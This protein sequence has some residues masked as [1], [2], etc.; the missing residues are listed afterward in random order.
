MTLILTAICKDGICICADRRYKYDNGLTEDK[1]KKTYKFQ[2]ITYVIA[3]HGLNEIDGKDWKTYCSEYEA[4]GG[5]KNKSHFSIV[6]DFKDYMEDY[7]R[8]ELS[9]HKDR[10]K[11]AMGFL[12]GGKQSTEN[13]YK[14][15][16]IHWLRNNN[17]TEFKLSPI[18]TNKKEP[19]IVSGSDWIKDYLKEYTEANPDQYKI[20]PKLKQAEKILNDLFEIAVTEKQKRK[21]GDFSDERD[22]EFVRDSL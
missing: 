22:I 6:N 17:E 11:N 9:R 21:S 8:K 18:H 1:H 3:H 16:E 15:S 5:W 20:I 2:G 12:L 7:V 13:K 10:E 14:V 4:S 19:L